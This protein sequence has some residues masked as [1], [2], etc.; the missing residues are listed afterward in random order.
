L[1]TEEVKAPAE[2][3]VAAEE[4][5]DPKT[6]VKNMFLMD[7]KNAHPPKNAYLG[8]NDFTTS[9]NFYHSLTKD[10]SQHVRKSDL[11]SVAG[12]T[13]CIGEEVDPDVL[14]VAAKREAK[15]WYSQ[16]YRDADHRNQLN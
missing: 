5:H 3:S 11:N 6:T 9:N 12:A 14:Q 2:C 16:Q 1:K 8:S 7:A 15:I 13:A 4:P 10:A